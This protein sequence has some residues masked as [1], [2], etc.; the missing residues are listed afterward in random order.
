MPTVARVTWRT[1]QPSVGTVEFWHG[2]GAPRWVRGA[3]GPAT[4]HEAWLVGVPEATLATFRVHAAASDEE[5]V[6]EPG[7]YTT[8]SLPAGAPRPTLTVGD[9]EEGVDSLTLV[10]VATLNERWTTIV[11]RAGRLVWAWGGADL[12][13]QRAHLTM[14]GRGVVM[15]DSEGGIMDLVRVDFNGEEQWRLPVSSGHH[16]FALVDDETFLVL[17]NNF[18]DVELEGETV[19]LQGDEVAQV[20]LSGRVQTLWNVWDHFVPSAD[21]S[22]EQIGDMNTW[23]WSHG[24]FVRY[25]PET[26]EV[27]LTLRH[28]HAATAF[29]RSSGEVLWTLRASPGGG[30]ALDFPHSVWPTA[31]GLLVFNQRDYRAGECSAVVALDGAPAAKEPEVSWA[32]EGPTCNGVYYVGN[33]QPLPDDK[34]LVSW[35]SSSIIE[36]IG[37]TDAE[38][39]WRLVYPANTPVLYVERIGSAG[40]PPE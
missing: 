5:V 37:R 13:T 18:R 20:D 32:Y 4:E 8:G 23:D 25:L 22:M 12:H 33:A 35:G 28:L 29:E 2:D 14:D 34:V 9:G 39:S 30:A 17:R 27:H 7:T 6:S 3:D 16:D 1:E 21:D 24:N 38:A 15:M 19:R 31:Q 36:E 26:D 40:R 11:D 10:P